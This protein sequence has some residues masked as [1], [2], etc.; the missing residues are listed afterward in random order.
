MGFCTEEQHR[1]LPG[2]VPGDREVHRRWRHPSDQ[3]TGSKSARTNRRSVSQ[4]ASTIRCGNGSSARW[5]SIPT[6][7]GTTIRARA[8]LM[9]KATDTKHAPWSIVRSERQAARAA[10]HHLAYP[11]DDSVRAGATSEGQTAE[12][13]QQGQ[14]RRSGIAEGPQAHR[15]QILT[16]QPACERRAVVSAP[17]D[18]FALFLHSLC[19]C[20]DPPFRPTPIDRPG[21]SNVAPART[22]DPKVVRPHICLTRHL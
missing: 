15:G 19:P 17:H 9:F 7:A 20:A 18:S 4:P 16:G 10:E 6:T 11:G 21:M 14:I 3:D 2:T 5:T 12:T 8:T 1:A 13:E 22:L